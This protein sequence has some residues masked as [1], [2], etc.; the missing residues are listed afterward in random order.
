MDTLLSAAV[1]ALLGGGII[2]ALLDWQRK[3][4]EIHIDAEKVEVDSREAETR[5]H[6]AALEA[7]KTVADLYQE[8]LDNL[9]QEVTSLREEVHACK[10]ERDDLLCRVRKLEAEVRRLGGVFP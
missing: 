3:G 5:A 4:Q 7:A 9:R 6:Q 8:A 10:A 1:G 2:K